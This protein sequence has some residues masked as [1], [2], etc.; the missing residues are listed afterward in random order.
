MH[1]DP[2]SEDHVEL[3]GGD[4]GGKNG[5]AIVVVVVKCYG[6]AWYPQRVV[7]S[8]GGGLGYVTEPKQIL[9]GRSKMMDVLQ[10]LVDDKVDIPVL[11]M[12]IAHGK[13]V[14]GGAI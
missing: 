9:F 3:G 12:G 5:G 13:K 6:E 10:Q 1:V 4:D 8:L 14:R 2:R 11:D 7:P